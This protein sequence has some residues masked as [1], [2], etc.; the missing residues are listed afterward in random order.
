M[1]RR[2]R[3]RSNSSDASGPRRS[4]EKFRSE[5]KK[6]ATERERNLRRGADELGLTEKAREEIETVARKIAKETIKSNDGLKWNHKGNRC[7][8]DFNTDLLQI[9][10]D[11]E[12][13]LKVEFNKK[14]EEIPASIQLLLEKGTSKLGERNKDLLRA[15]DAG[16]E[17]VSLFHRDPLCSS[18]DEEERWKIAKAESKEKEKKASL[19][20]GR[21]RGR[22]VDKGR[23]RGFHPGFGS[24][25][26]PVGSSIR[27]GFGAM[28][29]GNWQDSWRRSV[30]TASFSSLD[31]SPVAGQNCLTV[32]EGSPSTATVGAAENLDT[33]PNIATSTETSLTSPPSSEIV[34]CDK[35]NL[36]DHLRKN[37]YL[38]VDDPNKVLEEANKLAYYENV[39]VD[40]DF[41]SRDEICMFEEE[42]G[43]ELK[44][45]DTLRSHI[46]FWE[47]SGASKFALSVIQNGYVPSFSQRPE[48]Y[49]EPN[50][51]SYKAHRLWANSAVEKLFLAGLVKKVARTDLHCCNPLSVASNAVGKL[52]LCIDL[53][54]HLNEVTKA[55]KFRI[56][57]TRDALQVVNKG[58]WAF[59]FDLKSAYHQIPIHDAY[60]K[61]LGFKILKENGEV[62][63]YCYAVMPFGW[64]D[65]CRVLTKVLKSPIERWRKMG[66]KCFIHVD[67]GFGICSSKAQCLTASEQ[68]RSDLISYGLLISE[69]KCSWGARQSLLWTG[70]VWDFK[71]F[72]LWISEEKLTRAEREIK[73]LIENKHTML[74]AKQVAKVIGML[75]SFALAMGAIVRFRTRSLLTTLARETDKY[76]WNARIRLGQLELDE[77]EFWDQSLRGLNGFRMRR[78]DKVLVVQSREMYS[79]A[80]D[81]QMAGAEFRGTRRKSGSEY[82]AYFNEG[83]R[84]ASSTFR[85]L[86]AI[87]EGL[88]VRGHELK[89]SL[90]R[91]GCDNWSAGVIVKVGS[92]KP[93]CHQVALR[94]ADLAKKFEIEL[95]PFWLSREESQVVEVDSLSKEVDTGDYK[96]STRD[97]KVLEQDF[98]PFSVDMFA[99]S[100]S[101][102]FS[103][104]VSRVACSQAAA[105]DAFTLD[106]GK[107]GFMF[108]HPPVGLIVR[109]LRYAEAC[110]AVG[111]L[112]VPHWPGSIFMTELRAAEC[113]GKVMMV[114]EF[115]PELISPE[116]IKSKTFHGQARFNFFVYCI[117]FSARVL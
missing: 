107:A 52:R 54:R 101:F 27:G 23:G 78:E 47:S 12:T 87:E 108:L 3:T 28:R 57:S 93:D 100:F 76:G 33:R 102:Q 35:A 10:E 36:P 106:W 8:Y 44:V 84:G 86:R 51:A 97:F 7:Q 16:W 37:S 34:N 24:M 111:L 9:N 80:S 61:Y 5:R 6:E 117:N 114:R 13:S 55:P 59:S 26:F 4:R 17:A 11:L 94:I 103:P 72:K 99:S 30:R 75:G 40:T 77:L 88:R 38:E 18:A 62:E 2:S 79:D 25:G 85:E 63:H 65:A 48:A 98:G 31:Y 45:K 64:N 49:E 41:D 43:I 67:D 113:E 90:V 29:G 19:M 95:E 81:F 56:E 32:S 74:A 53:S 58:D 50:N 91:W 68:I 89:G 104:F 82:Q 112:V 105:V 110:K 60:H 66:I 46:S 73:F 1:S 109:V 115:Q 116:W 20:R 83:E 71:K 69:S 22:G 39:V 42:E 70:F 14:D 21:G 92:M 15:D 96:L